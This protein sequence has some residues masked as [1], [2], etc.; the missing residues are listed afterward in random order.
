MLQRAGGGGG[1][2]PAGGGDRRGPG[3]Q[4]QEPS[5][6]DAGE[7]RSV[8]R[9]LGQGRTSAGG[10]RIFQR[11]QRRGLREGRRRTGDRDGPTAASS[12]VER[13]VREG[14]G[15]SKGPDAGRGDGASAE[16]AAGP[17]AL[18]PAQTDA[19]A[20]V[21]HH[22]IRARIPSILAARPRE[23][24]RRVESRDHGL[25]FEADVHPRSE[26]S[27]GLSRL[28]PKMDIRSRSNCINANPPRLRSRS[29]Q[30]ANSKID[31]ATQ[32]Q[33]TQ[34]DRLLGTPYFDSP[35]SSAASKVGL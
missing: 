35:P 23:S 6:T 2:Q 1:G 24:S 32:S 14:A 25:E 22:Q 18:R 7:D 30:A 17:C 31:V 16:D 27:N 5:R 29:I 28:A 12:A 20:G 3:S 8:V 21:R 33:T 9:R 10:H 4:R 11:W 34:P 26:L 19:G 13:T 15:R